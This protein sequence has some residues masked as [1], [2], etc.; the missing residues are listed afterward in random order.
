MALYDLVFEGGGAKGTAFVG[1]M[2]VLTAAGHV[3]RRL[4]GTSA[5]AI[6]ATLIGAG[7]SSAELLRAC[8]ETLPGTNSPVFTTFMDTPTADNFTD[9]IRQASQTMQLL[10]DGHIPFAG[11]LLSGMLKVDL[12][13]EAFSFN[14]C[15]GFYAGAAFLSW[16][17]NKLQEIGRAHV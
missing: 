12:Y 10:H 1:A 3:H 5:G 14:E 4:V 17:R 11:E 15:G 16:F 13:R 7:Y 9:E 6:T 8:T 2:E